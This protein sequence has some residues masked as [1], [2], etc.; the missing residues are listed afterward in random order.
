MRKC[1][2]TAILACALGC[3][4][5][6]DGKGNVAFTTWGE[7]FIEKEIPAAT[8]EDGWS[9]KYSKFLLVLR[10]ITVADG[11]TVAAKQEKA[12]LFDM[13]KP[14]VKPVVTFKDLDAKNWTHVSYQI[15]PMSADVELGPGVTDA[16][17]QLMLT[18]KA[19][20]HVEAVA[21]KAG[22]SKSFVWDFTT[23]T[24]FDGCRGEKDGK[25]TEGVL[26]TN[27]GTDEVQL[28]IHGDHLY[29]DDL[30]AAN[31]K[32]R[33]Q[34]IADADADMD[35]K[36]TQAELGMVRLTAIPKANGAYG[37]G[38]A[39][40]V[41]TLADYVA[42]LSRTVGHYRGEGECFAKDPK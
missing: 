39:A 35:G 5:S 24:L 18:A 26:V 21:S 13:T 16:D 15:G 22:V 37:T 1:I 4:S 23:P 34:A 11:T 19:V 33:F 20:T 29:Y 2:S 38:G 7:E 12:V 31:A 40:G 14:G 32:M 36:I 3:S 42:A 30:Q 6:D 25:E 17:R 28:T 8:F 9:V 41:N 27:G 10:A